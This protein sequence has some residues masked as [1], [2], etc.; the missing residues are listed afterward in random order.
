[1]A[2]TLGAP[3]RAVMIGYETWSSMMSGLRSQREYTMTW[4]SDKSGSASS[5][6]LR[7]VQYAIAMATSV[8]AMTRYLFSAEK[9][10]IRLSTATC[11][12]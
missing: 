10:M 8:P 1:M 7:M 5:G 9:R 4:V 11:L 12:R 3:R 6:M 2:L